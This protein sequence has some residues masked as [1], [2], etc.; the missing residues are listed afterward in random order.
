MELDG[1]DREMREKK[2]KNNK[3]G[4]YGNIIGVSCK[5]D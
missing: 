3:T 5:H 4:W 1:S 2:Y